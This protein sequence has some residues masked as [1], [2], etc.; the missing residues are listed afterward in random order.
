MADKEWQKPEIKEVA[1]ETDEDVLAQCWSA[2]VP[3][4][5]QGHCGLG[6]NLHSCPDFNGMV[7]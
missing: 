3:E 5:M 4:P 2:S 1:L 7:R 6:A